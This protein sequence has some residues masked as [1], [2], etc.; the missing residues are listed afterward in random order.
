MTTKLNSLKWGIFSPDGFF[1]PFHLLSVASLE[2]A[3]RSLAELQALLQENSC[4]EQYEK[5]AVIRDEIN[6]RLK[7]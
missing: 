4:F 2:Y 7:K 3:G 6:K 5:C 1:Q